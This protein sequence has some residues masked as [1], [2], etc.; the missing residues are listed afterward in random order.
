MLTGSALY[1]NK[2]LHA[3]AV[4][5]GE[6]NSLLVL[7]QLQELQSTRIEKLLLC[8]KTWCQQQTHIALV[9]ANDRTWVLVTNQLQYARLADNMLYTADG[10]VL[11]AEFTDSMD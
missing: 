7:L 6:H 11:E 5:G 3:F 8:C 2:P 1:G 10:R 4:H 9:C